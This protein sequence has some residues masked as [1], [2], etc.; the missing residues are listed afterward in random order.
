MNIVIREIFA[1]IY[2]RFHQGYIEGTVMLIWSDYD[3]G[4]DMGQQK[5]LAGVTN[6]GSSSR[7]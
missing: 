2:P 5:R 1:C 4:W 3:M 7:K 6:R